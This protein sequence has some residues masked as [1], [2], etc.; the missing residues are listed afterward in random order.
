LARFGWAVALTRDGLERTDILA[1]DTT[2]KD[3]H[4]VEF[5]V[6]TASPGT[7]RFFIGAK[8]YPVDEPSDNEWWVLVGLNDPP[9]IGP[10]SYILPRDH[11]GAGNWIQHHR[12]LNDPAVAP[13]R[14]NAPLKDSR[15]AFE[16][17]LGYEDRWDLMKHPAS[18]APVLLPPDFR[19][20]AQDESID[21]PP[22][23]PWLDALPD[24]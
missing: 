10:L 12:W 5:Q 4:M 7:E 8:S 24:W 15:M 16:V 9:H 22:Q 6:I 17:V 3:R 11:L 23:H 1:V 13:G 14:R 21:L 19:G 2:A 18:E 20:F